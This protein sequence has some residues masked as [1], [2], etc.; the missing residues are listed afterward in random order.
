MWTKAEALC[1]T[2]AGVDDEG[3]EAID[4]FEA[5]DSND[6]E[7]LQV[8]FAWGRE[9]GHQHGTAVC[10]A[11]AGQ[12]TLKTWAVKLSAGCGTMAQDALEQGDDMEQTNAIGN[13]PL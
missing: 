13:T 2:I 12:C 1:C 3:L 7:L 4:M 11:C 6:M 8:R 10:M 5:I 9:N